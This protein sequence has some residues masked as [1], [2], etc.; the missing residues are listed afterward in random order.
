MV[1]TRRNAWAGNFIEHG[2]IIKTILEGASEGQTP[3]EDR[4]LNTLIRLGQTP[5]AASTQH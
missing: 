4:D 5:G 2:K 1:R 3:E